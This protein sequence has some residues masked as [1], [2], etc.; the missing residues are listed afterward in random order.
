[1]AWTRTIRF[2]LLTSPVFL[3][4]LL[5]LLAGRA[6]RKMVAPPVTYQ[7]KNQ[8]LI[9][10]LGVQEG[11]LLHTALVN[12]F[13]G[14]TYLV[15]GQEFRIELQFRILGPWDFKVIRVEQTPR[16]LVFLLQ[17]E[18]LPYLLELRY[19]TEPEEWFIRKSLNFISPDFPA[20][21]D[22]VALSD[23]KPWQTPET[24]SGPGQPVYVGDFFFGV[25]YPSAE[26]QVDKGRVVC[27]YPVGL[28]AGPEGYLSQSAVIGAGEHEKV[29]E[30]FLAYVDR[31]RS[32]P[33]RPFLLYNTWYDLRNYSDQ[34]VLQTLAA[35]PLAFPLQSVVLDDGWDDFQNL[36]A[37]HPLRFPLGFDPVR[38]AAEAHGAELGLWLSPLG[39]YPTNQLR[40]LLAS[41]GQGFEKSPLGFCIAGKNYQQWF[42][43][44]MLKYARENGVNY[45]KLDNLTTRC[46]YRHHGHRVGRFGQ[47]GLTDAF[48]EV[49][50]AV[51]HEN[52][53]IMINI[54]RGAWLSPWWLRHCDVVWPGGL[55]YY[56][57]GEG[58]KRQQSITYRDTILYQRL[59]VEGAQFPIHSLMTHGI[60]KG[61]LQDLGDQGENLRDFSDDAVMFFGRGVMMWEL[62]GTPAT[63]SA[64]EWQ[65][66][67]DTVAWARQ[68][69]ELL[70]NSRMVLGDPGQGRVYGYAHR[71]GK[72]GLLVVRNPAAKE[73]S[74]E[75]N[76]SELLG[77]E[78]A[79][80]QPA[81][82]V[83]S[84]AGAWQAARLPSTG[85]GPELVEGSSPKSMPLPEPS[86]VLPGLSLAVVQVE[87]P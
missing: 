32:Y 53:A 26:N 54:T 35:F 30:R 19:W 1:M 40:R 33:V 36:W 65:F 74:L 68:N 10:T 72:Q 77:P 48:I 29:R 78:F 45:F 60:I 83:Y 86:L 64:G 24:F 15:P 44:Q 66:L 9:L 38:S 27:A 85:S 21:V 12:R 51:K 52:P 69:A 79:Q 50:D 81:E 47:A 22:R 5:I 80:A 3:L 73:Q 43:N 87:V 42:K 34:E 46:P 67:Q 25:E 16:Q 82:L 71:L 14:K 61:R 41:A 7:L 23:F 2:R 17:A 75:L 76:W 59:R 49:I 62:Y 13:T 70:K 58:S 55:D 84:S 6:E 20:F 8:G 31:I 37:P 18:Q 28:N 11:W 4:C 56:Y 39:G 57:Q 63:L